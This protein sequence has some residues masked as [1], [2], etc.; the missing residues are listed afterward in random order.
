MNS[1][2]SPNVAYGK[3]SSWAQ[4]LDA[5][6]VESLLWAVGVFG[7]LFD[8][9]R[10]KT[11][12]SPVPTFAPHH[13]D[14][15]RM[16]IALESIADLQARVEVREVGAGSNRSKH[17]RPAFAEHFRERLLAADP[18]ESW[19][20]GLD[21][22]HFEHLLCG[23]GE[24]GIRVNASEGANGEEYPPPSFDVVSQIENLMRKALRVIA[25][26]HE[27]QSIDVRSA[28]KQVFGDGSQSGNR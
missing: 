28:T 22:Q 19:A 17:A 20:A 25:A 6:S 5:D 18:F 3:Y 7:K 2:V 13:M 27:G 12:R 11:G 8:T 4:G 10:R 23:V 26:I 14:E 24:Y 21:E 16:R 9:V 1:V 15:S